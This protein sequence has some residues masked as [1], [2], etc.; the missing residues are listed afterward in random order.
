L[1]N[2]SYFAGDLGEKILRITK[3]SG[4]HEDLILEKNDALLAEIAS[5]IDAI[6]HK[7]NPVVSG[8]DGKEALKTALLIEQKIFA[9]CR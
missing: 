6:L 8:A 2:E 1:E 3:T 7:K 5:F 4:D 9:S